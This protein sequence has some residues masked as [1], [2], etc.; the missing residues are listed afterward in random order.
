M[1]YESLF[2]RLVAGL[3]EPAN[4]QACWLWSRKTDRQGYGQ[5]NVWVPGLGRAVTMKAHIALW[6][7]Y[8]ASDARSADDLYLAYLTH[9]AS[10]LELDHLCVNP[11][12]CNPDHLEL[13]TG[14]ENTRRA[15]ERR[16]NFR[17]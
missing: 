17:P 5:L 10:G 14:A 1:A 16:L 12:C 4:E 9:S 3:H 7:Q 11:G 2:Q 15:H 13:V 6:L 8:A